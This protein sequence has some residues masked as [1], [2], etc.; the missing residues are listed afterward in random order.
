MCLHSPIQSQNTCIDSDKPRP[1]LWRPYGFRVNALSKR[2]ISKACLLD[3][4][5]FGLKAGPVVLV[6]NQGPKRFD[7]INREAHR[8]RFLKVWSGESVRLI[9]LSFS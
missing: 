8:A 3:M 2:L 5:Q 1:S 9:R 4:V 7:L 6:R